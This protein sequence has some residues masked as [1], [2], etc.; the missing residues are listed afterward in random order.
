[1]KLTRRALLLFFVILLEGYV[2][3]AS[4]LLAIRLLVPFVGSGVE[5]VAIIISA[6]LLPLAVGYHRGGRAL[7]R[8]RAAGQLPS[9]RRF[10]LRNVLSA[11]IVLTLGLSYLFL[12]L[13]FGTLQAIGLDSLIGQTVLYALMFLVMPVYLLGQTV[14][15][16][17]H[18]FAKQHLS[19]MTGRM[20]FSPPPARSPVRCLPRWC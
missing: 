13:F 1:M 2:V 4:E 9:V 7:T 11:Q 18:Y 15:L 16:I 3:L 20:L 5:V 10:L 12:E 19:E 6:V 8:A 14:P 17:S